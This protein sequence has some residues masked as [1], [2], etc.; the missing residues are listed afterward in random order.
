[1]LAAKLSS[2]N[3]CIRK[4]IPIHGNPPAL[5]QWVSLVTH[6][7]FVYQSKRLAQNLDPGFQVLSF[8]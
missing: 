5:Q 3:Y 8:S 2:V 1:M 4:T 7:H 6:L